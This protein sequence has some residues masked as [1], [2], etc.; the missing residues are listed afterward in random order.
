VPRVDVEL[1]VDVRAQLRDRRILRGPPQHVHDIARLRGAQIVAERDVRLHELLGDLEVVRG[2]RGGGAPAV[3]GLR[4]LLLVVVALAGVVR[5]VDVL[6]V[7][8]QRLVEVVGGV[9]AAAEPGEHDAGVVRGVGHVLVE[10]ERLVVRRERGV[11]L[12][13]PRQH[14]AA[15]VV[16][17]GVARRPGDQRVELGERFVE[18][19]ELLLVRDRAV[20]DGLRLAVGHGHGRAP[21]EGEHQEHEGRAEHS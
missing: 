17:L 11:I 14:P 8:D 20:E 9:L 19:A 6:R 15:R 1:V 3:G 18:L 13:L 2:E 21:A 12:A 5:G 4:E 10:R 16:R 7:R